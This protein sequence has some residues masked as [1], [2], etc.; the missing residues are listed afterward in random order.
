MASHF[1]VM[2]LSRFVS[3]LSAVLYVRLTVLGALALLPLWP[4]LSVKSVGT[5][6]L[7]AYAAASA[8][9]P[10]SEKETAIPCLYNSSAV[11]P[12]FQPRKAPSARR[13]YD[14]AAVIH[15]MGLAPSLMF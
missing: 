1:W 11:P 5:A 13:K 9:T 3:K 14:S 8:L 4:L 6:L 7:A 15:T 2:I 10:F 12:M